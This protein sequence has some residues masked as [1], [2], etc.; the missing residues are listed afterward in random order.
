MCLKFMERCIFNHMYPIVEPSLSKAQHGFMR[1]KSCTTQLLDMYHTI[2]S[3]L[4]ASGQVDIIYLNFSK[5]LDSVN[6]K[7]LLHKLQ[8]FGINGNILSWFNSY[9][10]NRIQRVVI[11]GNASDW[12]VTSPLWS[13]LGI[14][15]GAT[16]FYF[17]YQRHAFI[18][19][20]L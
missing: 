18:L 20:L 3:V 4:D 12:M 5:A 1:N 13:T 16:P 15:S 17:I 19:F 14:N 6:H 8:S 9:L 2:C 10:T 11:E 7:L